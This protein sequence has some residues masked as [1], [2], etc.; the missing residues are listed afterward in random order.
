MDFKAIS[1]TVDADFQR[2][3]QFIGE[4]LSSQVPLVKEIG[5][6]IIQSGG[7]RL[8]PLVCVLSAKALGYQGDQHIDV[9]TCVEF[10]HTAT[11]L[12]DDVVDESDLRRGKASAHRVWGNPASVLVGDFLISRA[13]QISD[14]LSLTF[15]PFFES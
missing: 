5:N 13:F 12:H 1:A 10:L 11:L 9:A 2:V 15:L 7:K 8:R 3:N 14:F 4:R 6:Y